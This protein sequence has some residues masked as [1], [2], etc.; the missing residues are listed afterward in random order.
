M[1]LKS[2]ATNKLILLLLITPLFFSG[3]GVYSFT[4]GSVGAAKSISI[5]NFVNESGG[6]ASLSQTLTENLR[7]YYQINTKLF[8]VKKDAD[9]QLEGKIT[10]YT[11]SPQAAQAGQTAGLNRLTIHVNA[12]FTNNLDPKANFQTDFTN[13]Q[14]YAG[15]QSIS[16]VENTLVPIILSN[17]VLQIFTKT[18]SNW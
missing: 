18:T 16:D 5:S 13:Y 6:P 11:V 2:R 17:I 10:A 9:W 7:N 14:D 4:G 12:K 15:T 3:C 8:L 1:R